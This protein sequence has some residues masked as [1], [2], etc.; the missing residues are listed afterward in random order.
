M[1]AFCAPV[2][3]R[4]PPR[5]GEGPASLQRGSCA[6]GTG[7]GWLDRIVKGGL[8]AATL[9]FLLPGQ[10]LARTVYGYEDSLGM[11]HTSTTK[12]NEHYKPLL[13]GKL[14]HE[15]LMRALREQ[16]ALGGPPLAR[17]LSV[18]LGPLSEA[19]E[20]IMG[21]AQPYLGAPYRLGG[22][23]ATGIDCSGLTKAVYARFG[24]DLPRQS[25]LQAG[26]GTPVAATELAPGDLLFFATNRDVGI[27]H[28]GIYLGSGRMLHSSPRRGG[29][30]VDRLPGTDYERWFVAARRLARPGGF[31]AAL[32][33]PM[34][35]GRR[36]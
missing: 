26:L 13:E 35:P 8:L 22:D 29:V 6:R 10:G 27:S 2:I 14:E 28:V 3:W 15:A 17:V 23:T 20:R 21:A 34:T 4:L 9:V 31:D 36:K 30:G 24:C 5:S 1:L 11:L 33:T 7:L 19:G 32:G 25:R 18:D 12:V 16:N